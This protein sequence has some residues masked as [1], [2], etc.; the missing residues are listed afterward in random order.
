MTSITPSPLLRLVFVLS[1]LAIASPGCA[2]Q[3]DTKDTRLS[4]ANDYFAADQ[5]D[6]AEKEFREVLRL[7]PNDPVALRQ[8]G[9]LYHDQGQLLQAYPLLK[10]AAE[11][12]PD[13]QEVQLKLGLT[14]LVLRQ[15]AEARDA[16]LQVLDKEPGQ[17]QALL[18]L[19][20]TAVAPVSN[21]DETRSLIESLRAKDRDR[22]GYHLALGT[23]DLRQKE[24]TR[25]EGEFKSALQLDP[26]SGVAHAALGLLYWSRNDL[27]AAEQEFKTAA[28]LAP[29]RSPMR[30]RYADFLLRTG[31]T[32][33]GKTVLEEVNRKIPDYLPPRVYLMRMACAKQQDEDCTTRA[34]NILAQDSTNYDALLQDGILNLAKGET[35]KAIREFGQL[36]TIYTQNP[37]VRYQLALAYLQFARTASPVNS[38]SAVDSADSNL[39]TAVK[40]DPQF[41]QA[42]VL[43]AGL[44]IQKGS[45]VAAEE[46]L[47]PLIKDRPQVAQAHYL[48]ATA[49]LAQQKRDQVLAAY[50]T[51]TD[52]FPQDPQ[53]QFL[54][55][56]I[57][58]AQGQQKE[59]RQAF[60]KSVGISQ[61]YLPAVERLVDLDIV[62]QKFAPA[63]ERVQGQID[64]DPTLAQP[65]ALRGKIYLAQRDFARAEPDLLKAIELDPKLEP[66]YLLLAQLYV[67]SNKQQQAIEKLN[68]FV[69]KNRTVP[70]LMLLATIH[71]QLKD[72]S[73]AR[74]AYEKVLTVA[75]N[76][77]IALNNLAVIYSEHLG[78]LDKAYDLA[79]KA[80]EAAPNEPHLADT[81]GWIQFKK[82]EYVNALQLL[83]ESA[84]K[85]PDR[86]EIL[87]HVG[88]AQYMLGQEEP[89]RLA[90]QK[91]A[92][93][94]ADF[95]GKDESRR[96]LAVLKIDGAT[97]N[98][99]V[100]KELDDYLRERPNDPAALVRLARLQERDGA[101]DQAIKTYEKVVDGNPQFAPALL[102]LVR[103]YDQHSVD[104]PKAYDLALKARQAYPQDAEVAKT[105]GI[106]SYRREYYP[107][108]AELLKEAAEKR[109]DDAVVLYYL[110]QAHHQLKQ[111]NECKALLERAV[112]LTLT[113]R[114]AD[115]AKRSLA[116]CSEMVPQ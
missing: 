98:A 31:S 69:E 71:E 86:S 112:T 1:F 67:A 45:P 2:K 65:W 55:G 50:R 62:D 68:G 80:R 49:Y 38:R 23:L 14:L 39:T 29:L 27:K 94:N 92:D 115:E 56:M 64:R 54:I 83:Q 41:E 33:A 104:T 26:K 5:Y 74:D 57:L 96:R 22:P 32:D 15:F 77:A 93:A 85:L 24:E 114:F 81:L 61:N 3:E 107:R 89:A 76:F 116:E 40:L 88:M 78:Q 37:Q 44:K 84:S 7:A 59:A 109:A 99:L 42:V 79:K 35:A 28:D 63:M 111:W 95:P 103:L 52:L 19:A 101:Q 73:A 34:Q 8:L 25:A 51:M 21:I 106:L 12:L 36:A 60:E 105:L 82:G 58:L 108:S 110:G 87:F 48:L 70:T 102:Q 47:V 66:A 4:R 90:L 72:F 9:I 6:K 30:L 46:L 17:D 53:P 97:A 18:L 16:A 10:Q 113:P 75:A 11:R 100:R 13:E 91:A 20:D 43:L